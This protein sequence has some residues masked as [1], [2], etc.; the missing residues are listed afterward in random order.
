MLKA[1]SIAT[2]LLHLG[3]N[4]WTGFVCVCVVGG[5]RW[6]VRGGMG[7]RRLVKLVKHANFD[8]ESIRIFLYVTTWGKGAE[9]LFQSR[10]LTQ[11]PETVFDSKT[12]RPS[13]PVLHVYTITRAA[14]I[15][16]IK[17]GF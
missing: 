9:V 3:T 1:V 16:P 15:F 8:I 13:Y 10:P 6:R 17:G 5:G 4:H 14:N 12:T 7:D 11:P 2:S